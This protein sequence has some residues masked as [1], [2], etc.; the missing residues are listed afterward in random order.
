M[1]K[2]AMVDFLIEL[3]ADPLAVDGSG[4]PPSAYAHHEVF[5]G[6]IV[7]KIRAMTLAELTAPSADTARPTSR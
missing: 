3:G 6:P 7:Q 4:S 1:N 5:D 2:P